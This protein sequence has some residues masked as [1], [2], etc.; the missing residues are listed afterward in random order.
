MKT[1]EEAGLPEDLASFLRAEIGQQSWPETA[2][3]SMN[4]PS[5]A[6]LFGDSTWIRQ[7]SD[8]SFT[9]FH[10]SVVTG[11]NPPS[12]EAKSSPILKLPK[13]ATQIQVQ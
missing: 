4:S 11:S 5:F 2:N 6:L 7:W 12:R 9:F 1:G 8:L 13:K 10:K 3:R